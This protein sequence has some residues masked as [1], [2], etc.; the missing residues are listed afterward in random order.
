MIGEEFR[1][2]YNPYIV[3]FAEDTEGRLRARDNWQIDDFINVT[4]KLVDVVFGNQVRFSSEYPTEHEEDFTVPTIVYSIESIV[5]DKDRKQL[6]HRM[7]ESFYDE[8]EQT[9]VAVY[10]QWYDNKVVFTVIARNNQQAYELA[11]QF[12]AM[13][14]K[15]KGVYRSMGITNFFFIEDEA[16]QVKPM[17]SARQLTYIVTTEDII[18]VKENLIESIIQKI[19]VQENSF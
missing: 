6:E 9:A 13:L 7:F 10:K 12:R 17:L 5:P 14:F 8:K 1:K 18:V 3:N 16:V 19:Q 4:K 2:D 15:Y 11:K